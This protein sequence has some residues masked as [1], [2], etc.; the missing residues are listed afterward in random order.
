MRLGTLRQ[1]PENARMRGVLFKPGFWSRA[2]QERALDLIRTITREA[3]LFVPRMPKSGKAL[4]VKMTN[5]GPLGWISDEKGY[6]Y[7]PT[8]PTT[9]LPWPPIPAMLLEAWE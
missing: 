3:P 7:E 4:S 6:R 1:S 5:C 9:G 8:H 2:E